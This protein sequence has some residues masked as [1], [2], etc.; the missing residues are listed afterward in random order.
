L[1]SD[2]LKS[3]GP[4]VCNRKRKSLSELQVRKL[5]LKSVVGRAMAEN[6]VLIKV[7]EKLGLKY[8]KEF[9]LTNMQVDL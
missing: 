2:F 1:V 8:E 5:N 7:L 3:T 4:K 6:A 9:N